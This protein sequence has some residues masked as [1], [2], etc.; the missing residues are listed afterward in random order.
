MLRKIMDIMKRKPDG[1]GL[2]GYPN[3]L[4]KFMTDQEYEMLMNDHQNQISFDGNRDIEEIRKQFH[5]AQLPQNQAEYMG[6]TL[7][8]GR[9]EDR[10]DGFGTVGNNLSQALN[11]GAQLAEDSK[12][13]EMDEDKKSNDESDNYPENFQSLSH[14]EMDNDA[15]DPKSRSVDANDDDVFK[16][17]RVGKNGK[18]GSSQEQII[19]QSNIVVSNMFEHNKMSNDSID[20]QVQNPYKQ[21]NSKES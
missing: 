17:M 8:A 5:Y 14:N 12:I 1:K 19:D 11:D 6:N 20:S 15:A 7:N 13:E 4:Q 9:S 2:E 16:S 21:T 18:S 10:Q 3:G